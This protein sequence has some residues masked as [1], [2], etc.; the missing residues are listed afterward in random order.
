M[1]TSQMRTLPR[2]RRWPGAQHVDTGRVPCFSCPGSRIAA[3]HEVRQRENPALTDGRTGAQAQSPAPA[4]GECR[5]PPA[6]GGLHPVSGQLCWGTRPGVRGCPRGP[7]AR[8]GLPRAGDRR[9]NP[10][11]RP[12]RGFLPTP[13]R[14]VTHRLPPRRPG[15]VPRRTRCPPSPP[16]AAAPGAASGDFCLPC[17]H[18]LFLRHRIHHH[19][20]RPL[21]FRPSL[22]PLPMSYSHVGVRAY[23]CPFLA[24]CCRRA[25]DVSP[26]PSSRQHSRIQTR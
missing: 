22:L 25:T 7:C 3:P 5:V 17:H 8:V 18:H 19:A 11:K 16:R 13:C 20:A 2:R 15:C 4:Q 23:E 1:M 10:S 14:R 21:S 24:I 12:T 26:C 6:G 9:S